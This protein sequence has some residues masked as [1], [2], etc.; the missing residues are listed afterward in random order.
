[1]KKSVRK[2][3]SLYKQGVDFETCIRVIYQIEKGNTYHAIADFSLSLINDAYLRGFEVAERNYTSLK[4]LSDLPIQ[5]E[6]QSQ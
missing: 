3:M 6:D 2:A 5:V 1:M 4:P